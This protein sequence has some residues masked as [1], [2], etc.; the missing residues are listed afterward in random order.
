MTKFEFPNPRMKS[1]GRS[2]NDE[3]V[4]FK[5][6]GVSSFG[7]RHSSFVRGFEFR[8]SSF[9]NRPHPCPLPQYRESGTRTFN[10]PK[11][12]RYQIRSPRGEAAW[13]LRRGVVCTR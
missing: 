6:R 2:T 12:C 8:H 9:P 7:V 10:V 1:E 11:G 13:S 3:T 5:N 4:V